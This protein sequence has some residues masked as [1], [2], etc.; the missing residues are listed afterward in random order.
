[1]RIRTKC[2]Q[3][4]LFCIYISKPR[5]LI[6]IYW[7]YMML[8][9][10]EFRHGSSAS[11]IRC[12]SCC[13]HLYGIVVPRKKHSI[14][15]RLHCFVSKMN[16]IRDQICRKSYTCLTAAT[17]CAFR[18]FPHQTVI[19]FVHVHILRASQMEYSMMTK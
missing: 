9:E 11:R 18:L 15:F 6:T 8:V 1:M 14:T 19:M 12:W 7:H 17:L 10:Y 5:E 3:F 16:Q 13:I 4:W 2:T